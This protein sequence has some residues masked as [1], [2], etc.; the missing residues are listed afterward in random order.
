[1]RKIILWEV[2]FTAK[3]KQSFRT[4]MGIS[5]K[6]SAIEF[7]CKHNVGEIYRVAYNNVTDEEM[8]REVIAIG[9]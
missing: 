4:F 8:S 6:V 9:D 5:G 1:M 7:A 2:Y 3:G